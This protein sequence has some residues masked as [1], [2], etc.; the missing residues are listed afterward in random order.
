MTKVGQKVIFRA[1][2]DRKESGF[3]TELA[4]DGLEGL[5]VG[6]PSRSNTYA[7]VDFANG[8]RGVCLEQANLEAV[9]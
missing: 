2:Q 1:R 6:I 3:Q 8:W 4:C 5:V 7:L 9:A